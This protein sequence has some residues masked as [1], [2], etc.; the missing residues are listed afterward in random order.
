M[1]QCELKNTGPNPQD[2][3]NSNA[4]TTGVSSERGIAIFEAAAILLLVLPVVIGVIG[5]IDFVTNVSSTSAALDKHLYEE[6]VRPFKRPNNSLGAE[7]V[8]NQGAIESY[9]EQV[10]EQIA[11]ELTNQIG[12]EAITPD[13][14]K[15][16]A[17][18][19]LFNVQPSTGALVS[20]VPTI[21][22]QK[23]AGSYQPQGEAEQS[24]ALEQK[25]VSYAQR[26]VLSPEGVEVAMIATPTGLYGRAGSGA[27][28]L[29]SAVLVG[30]R[31]VLSLEESASG[32]LYAAVGGEA[33]A[34]DS[35]VILL[36]GEIE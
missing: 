12:E 31:V 34:Y 1:S 20:A 32:R 8:V 27:A 22:S 24:T 21:I 26:Y 9:L 15:I 19:V 11:L 10:V 7:I 23:S 25:F 29:D 14:Y 28:F 33:L 30:A 5:L 4:A 17:Q 2:G 13:R 36:R 3:I 18:A 35:K 6:G 16:E